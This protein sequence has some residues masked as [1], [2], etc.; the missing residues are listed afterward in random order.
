MTT[1]GQTASQAA[2]AD[3]QTAINAEKSQVADRVAALERQAVELARELGATEQQLASLDTGIATQ[4][5][6]TIT[7]VQAILPDQAPATGG[8]TP[9][10]P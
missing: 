9:T 2:F 10:T 3:L 4:I 6:S 7:E 5:R 1:A 8:E